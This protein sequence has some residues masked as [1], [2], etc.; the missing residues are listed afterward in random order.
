M[1]VNIH[2]CMGDIAS[3]NYG[4]E[5]HGPCERCGMEEKE[6]CCHTEHKLIKAGE[7]HVGA[8][9]VVPFGTTAAIPPSFPDLRPLIFTFNSPES[10]LYRSPPDRRGNDYRVFNCVYRI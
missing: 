7:D 6:G 10:S 8:K 9:P 4:A 3:V 2:Y 1:V 5:D